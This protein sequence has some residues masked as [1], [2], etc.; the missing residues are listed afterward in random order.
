MSQ[1][2]FFNGFPDFHQRHDAPI[3]DEFRRLAKRQSWRMK[4]RDF[5]EIR[6]ECLQA[7]FEY[8]FGG[9]EAG[10]K[11]AGWQGLCAE[12]GLS[13]NI[14]SIKQ[15]RK[16]LKRVHVNILDLIDDRRAGRQIERYSSARALADYTNEHKRYFPLDDTQGE[17]LIKILLKQIR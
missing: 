17:S 13:H 15:C 9:I 1:S 16:A 3:L 2:F 8:H 7:E 10:N 5:K 6:R 14:P 11:L 12:L 4:D